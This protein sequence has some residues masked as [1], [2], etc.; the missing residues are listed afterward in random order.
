MSFQKELEEKMRNLTVE[1][2]NRAIKKYFKTYNKWTVVKA[3]DF[4]NDIKKKNN[5]IND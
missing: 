3:G 5:Q 2:V 1:D 4:K